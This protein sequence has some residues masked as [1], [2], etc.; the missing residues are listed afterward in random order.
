MKPPDTVDIP[1]RCP[2]CTDRQPFTVAVPIT[3][4]VRG[5][6]MTVTLDSLPLSHAIEAHKKQ[7]FSAM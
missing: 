4:G 6:V 2:R 1:I 7:H 5:D 3:Y